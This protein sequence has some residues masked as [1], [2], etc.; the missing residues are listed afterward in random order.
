MNKQKTG[1]LSALAAGKDRDVNPKATQTLL[2][3]TMVDIAASPSGAV[4]LAGTGAGP[5]VRSSL[6][7]FY[8]RPVLPAE[9][10]HG[11]NLR[12]QEGDRGGY[13]YELHRISARTNCLKFR[14]TYCTRFPRRVAVT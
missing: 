5:T 13:E 14:P 11:N 4:I 2:N 3:D 12:L 9:P 10:Q 7:S 1:V 6:C 8:A